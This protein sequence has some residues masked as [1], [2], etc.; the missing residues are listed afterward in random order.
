MQKSKKESFFNVRVLATDLDGTLIPLPDRPENVR[1]L[2]ELSTRLTERDRELIFCTG[3]HFESVID[4]LDEFGLPRPAWMI[5]GVGSAMY[6]R[7][8]DGYAR[9]AP[10]YAH[11]DELTGHVDREGIQALLA[12]MEGLTLQCAAHQGE[13]KISYDCAAEA[14]EGLI[15][16]IDRRLE[17]H[18]CR[19][20]CMGSVDPFTGGGL[21]DLLPEGVTKA[22]ALAW[23]STHGDFDPEE[24]VY[25]GDSG[26]D[27]AALTH[28]FRAI[29]VG[30]AT[31]ALAGQVRDALTA[32][33]MADRFYRAEG[34]ATSGVLEGC[35]HFGLV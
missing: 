32:K 22:Y 9:F 1:A 7:E 35:G 16:E 17:Q 19:F 8:G 3:R 34:F 4:A 21:V 31:E 11:L 29:V 15:A 18:G 23:L 12:D 25:A 20:R 33:G 26:N 27:L 14:M 6:V 5:C 30:N 28:G 10:Y 2:N 24:V 13:Y